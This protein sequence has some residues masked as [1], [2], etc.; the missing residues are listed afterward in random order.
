[1]AWRSAFSSTHASPFRPANAADAVRLRETCAAR[2]AHT[3]QWMDT[4]YLA[5]V[6]GY[7]VSGVQ[8]AACSAIST[9][10]GGGMS[11]MS[12]MSQMSLGKMSQ[13]SICTQLT[14]PHYTQV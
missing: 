10:S 9:A 8:S 12:S 5:G 2:H 4:Q 1:M 6:S 14:E 3:A 7:H 13:L 11:V